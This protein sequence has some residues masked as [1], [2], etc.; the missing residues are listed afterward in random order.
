MNWRKQ[1]NKNDPNSQK[2][3]ALEQQLKEMRDQTEALRATIAS[4]STTEGRDESRNPLANPL[5]QRN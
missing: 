1:A 5:T 4:L 3:A 2:V